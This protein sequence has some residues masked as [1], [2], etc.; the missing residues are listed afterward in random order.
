MSIEENKAV[1]QRIWNEILNE[2]KTEK[3]NE[4]V[5][6]DYVYH[7]PGG[8]EIKGIEGFKKFMTWIHNSFPGVHFTLDDLIAE[9][10][11]VVSF[12]T[13]KGPHKS[14]KQV[15]F[16]G[17][18]ICRIVSGKEVEVWEIFDRLTIASQLAPG[19][20][21]KAMVNF[22]VKQMSKDRP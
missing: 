17:I 10:D 11:K 18:V 16:Q 4:L 2:G 7:G 9:G 3:S 6:N 14:N 20:I 13:M 21:A 5:A 22:I 8:H 1:I 19:W 15:N 12:F